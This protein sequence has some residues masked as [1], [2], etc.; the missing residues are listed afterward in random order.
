MSKLKLAKEKN[1]KKDNET[2]NEKN[3]AKDDSNIERIVKKLK[4]S[5][6]GS[7]YT[8]N[9][10]FWLC[11]ESGDK[12]LK[13]SNFLPIPIRNIIV[14]DDINISHKI[15]LIGILNG[16]EILP[17]ICIPIEEIQKANCFEHY[18]GFNCIVESQVPKTYEHIRTALKLA[19]EDIKE[20]TVYSHIGW[21]KI[22]DKYYYLHANGGIGESNIEAKIDDSM[23]KYTIEPSSLSEEVAYTEIM[24]LLKVANNEVTIPIFAYSMLALIN[25][26]LKEAGFEP[27]FIMWLHGESGSRK[28][29][30]ARLFTNFF[31]NSDIP[32]ATFKDT[33]AG[34]EK[35][36][37]DYKDSVLVL[38]DFHP[39]TNIQEKDDMN[40][41][42]QH[43]IRIYGDRVTKKR[44]TSNLEK[45]K[46]F[47]PRGLM[48]VTGEDFIGGVS[49]TARCFSVPMKR[50]DIKLNKLTHRQQ[51]PNLVPTAVYFYIKYLAKSMES[52]IGIL[53]DRFTAYR[54]KYRKDELHGRSSENMAWL[55]ISYELY[56]EYGKSIKALKEKDKEKMMNEAEN[57]FINLSENQAMETKTEDPVMMYLSAIKELIVSNQVHIDN[58]GNNTTN[59]NKI[60]WQDEKFYY[61][62]PEI[63][64][65]YVISFWNRQNKTFPLS[66]K[67]IYE[68]LHQKDIIKV[69]KVETNNNLT[70]KRTVKKK[71]YEDVR[72][73]ALQIRK[74]R[75]NE[76]IK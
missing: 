76:Y 32:I 15:E 57:I 31:S 2:D 51:T 24:K 62:I 50:D 53:K 63:T 6:K 9:K 70:Y 11:K 40:K 61:L 68:M 67:K 72:L 34:I 71:V 43:F 39:S 60:G 17:Q 37:F 14:D 18:W 56:L 1:N 48:L 26:P 47:P 27:K 8:V 5:L 66:N 74:D 10:K 20:L 54:D 30:L 23:S 4:K 65:S 64:H 25:F 46:E 42:A 59:K 3:N 21:R 58:L 49:S 44:M 55:M 13:L 33:I 16:K 45:H 52:L 22:E 28:T 12:Y 38:D 73:R 69:E 29:T 7:V 36:T 35:L 19:A 41:K 75:M